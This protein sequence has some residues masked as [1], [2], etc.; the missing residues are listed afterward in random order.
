MEKLTACPACGSGQLQALMSCKDYTVSHEQFNIDCCLGCGLEFTN[1]RPTASGIGYYYESEE[2]VSHTDEEAPGLVNTIYREV[3]K[4][5]LKQKRALIEGLSPMGTLLDIG[6]GTGTF[7]GNMQRAGWLVSAV[8]PDREAASRAS[9][10]HNIKVYSEAWLEKCTETFQVVTMWHVL[11]HVHALKQRFAE[12]GRLLK[13]GGILVIAVPNPYSQDAKH[14]G[15]LWAARDVPRH[16]YHFPPAMLR[17]RVE[18]EG[19]EVVATKNMHF[20][21][22][23][24]SLLSEKYKSDGGGGLLLGFTK[25]FWFWLKSLLTPDTGSSQ[26]YIFRKK[27]FV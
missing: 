12:L 19:F 21:P 10:Q 24:I 7:A 23:Y 26:I 6:C 1:P 15:A 16:L 18:A 5:T 4:F 3:R 17:K 14:Y 9:M 8:E 25:G 11:E 13:P 22:F 20:D 27:P 2:Y